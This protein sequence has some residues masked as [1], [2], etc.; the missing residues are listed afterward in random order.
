VC[1]GDF[2]YMICGTYLWFAFPA[3]CFSLFVIVLID[4]MKSTDV[5]LQNFMTQFSSNSRSVWV[6]G[7][8]S[9]GL[10]C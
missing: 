7:T 1:V 9:I 10:T 5:C 8:L 4:A 6:Q 3:C 2:F